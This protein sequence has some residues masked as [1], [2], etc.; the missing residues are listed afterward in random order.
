MLVYNALKAL[1]LADNSEPKPQDI[2]ALLNWLRNES[3]VVKEL[4][5]AVILHYATTED[6]L[7][8]DVPY[9]VTH[10]GAQ[11]I[12]VP[13]KQLPPVLLKM[14]VLMPHYKYFLDFY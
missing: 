11:G 13:L 9:G 14:L 6:R 3:D 8:T 5:Y 2:Q 7:K 12:R 10:P 1:A 4:F